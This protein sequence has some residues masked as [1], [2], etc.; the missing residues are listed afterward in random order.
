MK[1]DYN[2]K[3]YWEQRLSNDLDLSTVG[4]IGLGHV[5][6][7]WLY[8]ARFRAV[9]RGI[10]KLDLPCSSKSL[11]DVGVGSGA[12]IP[13]W[14]DLGVS[15]I[16]GLDITSTS[17]T[18]LKNKYPRFSFLQGNICDPPPPAVTEQ[19][20]LVTAFDIL[21]HI[22]DDTAFSTAISNISHLVKYGGWVMLTDSFCHKPW[23]PTYH[24]YHRTRDHYLRQLHKVGLQSDHVEPI[25]FT[26][27]TTLCACNPLYA[28]LLSPF[29]AI[30]PRLISKLAAH[31]TTE[32][33]NQLI[34]FTLYFVDGILSRTSKGGPSLKILFARK[35]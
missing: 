20:D 24:E 33:F 26:M 28:H 6:N 12:W 3:R 29:T 35:V 9:R 10:R 7:N 23:G 14:Q 27:T 17:V 34:G 5:Y 25:F 22:T 32:W 30:I 2:P 21:F 11:L 13:F 1:Q 4:Q 16:V 8:K 31:Q 15:T 18:T 19:F